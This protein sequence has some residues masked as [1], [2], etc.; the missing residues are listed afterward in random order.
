MTAS[1]SPDSPLADAFVMEC[2]MHFY[3]APAAPLK[4]LHMLFPE[5]VLHKLP[6]AGEFT[7]PARSQF[8]RD[9]T[10]KGV[11]IEQ[12]LSGWHP[13]ILK[14]EDIQDN[15]NSQTGYALRKVWKNLQVNVKM[16]PNWG[17]RDHTGTRYGPADVYSRMLEN[18][19][20][21]TIILWKPAYLRRP[22]ALGLEDGELT[23]GDVILQFPRLLPWEYLRSV[24]QD[25]EESFW[26]QYMNIAEGNFKPTFPQDR[27]QA[28][29]VRAEHAPDEQKAHIAWRFE[30][31][32]CKHAACAVG[33][34]RDGRM[35]IVE[36]L[37]GQFVPTQLA[38]R[39]VLTAKKWEAH[40]VE[41][42]DTPGARS[43]IPHIRNVA[44]ENDW[45]VELHWSPFMQDDT[46]RALAIKS[47]EPHLLAGKLL[48]AD[49]LVNGTELF[50]QMYQ[51]GMVEE[52]ELASV[53]ARVANKLP[54]SN[55]AE[56]FEV[57]DEDAFAAYAEQDAYD[58]VYGRG[59]YK[60][61]EPMLEVEEAEWQPSE[62]GGGLEEMM[63]GLSG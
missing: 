34:E 37:R 49:D 3:A 53:T 52:Y 11:S 36:V 55:A 16:L 15:R 51:F 2:A 22:H 59:R 62:P 43:M 23:E 44:L 8:R 24:K 46:A 31:S 5:H 25:D 57:H 17:Y 54:A 42:E 26:T 41:I 21:R 39:V 20:P 38:R 12:S 47:C 14:G 7:T 60:E 6:K 4:I 33:I 48:F 30:Y 45:R 63:P 28:A 35:T 56:G 40:R 50:R 1:N 13:D 61:Q 10:V 29:K 58:R 19:G 27:L 32:E 9:P 18:P